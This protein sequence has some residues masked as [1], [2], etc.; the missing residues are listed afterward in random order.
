MIAYAQLHFLEKTRSK[1]QRK[2]T[3]PGWQRHQI[4]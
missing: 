3:E 1:Q 4:Q 2:H